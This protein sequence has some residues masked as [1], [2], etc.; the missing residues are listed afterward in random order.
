M[1]ADAEL[2]RLCQRV[3]AHEPAAVARAISWVE[4]RRP[5][6][7]PR[8]AELLGLL[9]RRGR[10]DAGHRVG[11]T[12]PPGVGKSS[13]VSA[14][15]REVRRRGR[16]IGVL[17][18]DPSS[19][20][21]GGA[22]LGDRARI[23]MDPD[24]NDFYVR[25]MASGGHLGGLARA[26][27]AAVEVLSAAFDLVLVE[28]TGVGQSETDVEHVADTV[29]LVVQPASGDVLQ[30]LKAGILEIPDLLAVNKADLGEVARRTGGELEAALSAIGAA[31]RPGSR[32]AVIYTSASSGTGI[33]ELYEAIVR[34][35]ALLEADGVLGERRL[36]KGAA[37][38]LRL[39]LQRFGEAGVEA[40]GGERALRERFRQQIAAGGSAT[41]LAMRRGA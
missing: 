3:L 29:V 23:L 25:S 15:A 2:E 35:R 10:A 9:R 33:D 24:D 27:G 30:F 39:F 26:A 38:A 32:P 28:T 14:L 20:R 7:E 13:L 12:G 4:D 6:A 36:A 1:S 31:G 22:L 17:A 21:S 41:A 5:A 34:H 16:S 40:A 37:W 19:P 8:S 11:I 18:V